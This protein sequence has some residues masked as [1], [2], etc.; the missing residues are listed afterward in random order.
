[1]SLKQP[2]TQV[3]LTNVAVVRY[4]KKGKRFEIAC[5]K[6]KVVSWRD[7]NEGDLD[8]VLQTDR[9]FSNVSKGVL[10]NSKDLLAAF[11]TDETAKIVLE[12]LKNGELQVSAGE[13]Q[14]QAGN[15]FNEIAV[16]VSNLCVDPSSNRPFSVGVIERAMR[17]ELHFAVAPNRPAKVQA[18]GVI[19][20]LEQCMNIR[21]AQMRLR[22]TIPANVAK[23][24]KEKLKG[25]VHS[26]EEEDWDGEYECVVLIDPGSYRQVDEILRNESRG[27]ATLEVVNLAVI[28]EVEEQ[29]A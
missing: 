28:V 4:K 2:I 24:A 16:I 21:R 14:H 11:K 26:W 3:R 27:Q 7:G 29:L 5:Y 13:R 12:I 6:N 15:L 18:Q 23:S 17:D 19:R 22:L 8:E 20:Q 1:M 9:I 25:H 10:A